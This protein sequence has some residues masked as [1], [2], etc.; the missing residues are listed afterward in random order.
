M[1]QYSI[2]IEPL[3]QVNKTEIDKAQS[4]LTESFANDPFIQYLM[5]GK[6]FFAIGITISYITYEL[7]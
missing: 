3:Y 1:N 6:S 7:L 5:V 4:V 2:Y